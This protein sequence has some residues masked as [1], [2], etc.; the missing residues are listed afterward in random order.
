MLSYL[1]LIRANL[2]RRRL[3]SAVTAGGVALAVALAFCLIAF[4][5]GYQRGLHAELDR[6]GAH[7]L[8]VPKG[9]PYDAASIALHGA[10]W[11]CYLKS[12]YLESVR[13]TAHVAIAAPVLMTALYDAQTGAQ[14]VYCGVTPEIMQLK[15]FWRID[16]A[17]PHQS[18]ELLL[19]AEL[20]RAH[21]WRIGQSIA[22][23]GL[24]GRQGHV[25]GILQPTQGADDLFAFLTLADAQRVFHRP[26][27]LTHI[28]VRLDDPEMVNDVTQQLRG[29]DAGLDMTVVPLSH[30]FHTIQNLVQS[31]RLLLAC[32]A[33]AALLAAA[34]GVSNTILMA[35]TE[36]TREIGVL[37]A[38]GASRATIFG[39]IWMET[40][41][42]CVVGG[43]VGLVLALGGAS[44]FEAWLRARLPF[45]PQDALV[46]PE[47]GVLL[48]CLGVSLALG[49]VAAFLPA[50]RAARL[51]PLE[52]IRRG[53]GV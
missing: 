41:V 31:T 30:L 14:N 7:L 11:P 44:A 1:S 32:V 22:L 3:R 27:Q 53:G 5:R 43:V 12:V 19:G 9:C 46:R 33:L 28:L 15:R 18:G 29:C 4:Q 21:G 42:L 49:T 25:A 23:P 26:N 51:S 24:E 20:A 38:V 52:A 37:R 40:L 36:R 13:H 39:L 6:L 16:G 8:V 50:W 35:V 10:S 48:F 34:S 17:F 45:A 2:L 47:A